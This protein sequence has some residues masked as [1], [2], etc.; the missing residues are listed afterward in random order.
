MIAAGIFVFLVCALIADPGQ[1]FTKAALKIS[2][3]Y[4]AP[5]Y[6]TPESVLEFAKASNIYYDRL[7]IPK[8]LQSFKEMNAAHLAAVPLIRIFDKNKDLLKTAIDNDCSWA[9]ADFF[10]R[11]QG[12][13]LIVKHD[14]SYAHTL[15]HITLLDVKSDQDTFDYYIMSNWA[16]YVPK[17]SNS[18]FEQI[19]VLK[20]DLDMNVC[21]ISINIDSQ[22]E[23][24]G[25]M[26]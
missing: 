14:S 9:L 21:F 18:L 25:E 16:K 12:E 15:Q 17:L 3:H 22:K 1:I 5:H 7:Y 13:G 4:R 23:W 20:K 6:E 10:H 26:E 19:S 2:G 8:S 24:E 11:K